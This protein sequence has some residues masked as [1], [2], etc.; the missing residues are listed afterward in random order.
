MDREFSIATCAS[1]QSLCAPQSERLKSRILAV[2]DDI[3]SRCQRRTI[4]SPVSLTRATDDQA[5]P[6]ASPSWPLTPISQRPPK[7]F[8]KVFV[9]LMVVVGQGDNVIGCVGHPG[10]RKDL[11][12]VVLLPQTCVELS[13][14]VTACILNMVDIPEGDLAIESVQVNEE[15]GVSLFPETTTS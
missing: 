11:E 1:G 7:R 15:P 14:T 3:N 2:V 13:C 6:S 10:H 9:L 4:S 12:L 5:R 8:R